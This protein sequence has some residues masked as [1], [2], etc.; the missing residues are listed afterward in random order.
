MYIFLLIQFLYKNFE[1]IIQVGLSC[2]FFA[3]LHQHFDIL[4]VIL[5]YNSY[6]VAVLRDVVVT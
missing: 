5:L 3:S 2:I 1:T 4:N 6:T